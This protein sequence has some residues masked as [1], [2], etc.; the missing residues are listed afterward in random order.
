MSEITISRNRYHFGAKKPDEERSSV[1]RTNSVLSGEIGGN[2]EDRAEKKAKSKIRKKNPNFAFLEDAIHKAE[3]EFK[4]KINPDYEK[5]AYYPPRPALKFIPTPQITH[6]LIFQAVMLDMKQFKAPASFREEYDSDYEPS[7]NSQ[8]SGSKSPV[9]TKGMANLTVKKMG[10]R[11]ASPRLTTPNLAKTN[12]RANSALKR[13]LGA[14][15]NQNATVTNKLTVKTPESYERVLTASQPKRL[16]S[17]K[18]SSVSASKA[19]DSLDH[20]LVDI[21]SPV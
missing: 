1:I 11:A 8:I 9:G 16:M 5:C 18:H 10:S 13:S 3:E 4:A 12:S 21:D 14:P 6:K 2:P 19:A 7:T 15:Q 20:S 17:R